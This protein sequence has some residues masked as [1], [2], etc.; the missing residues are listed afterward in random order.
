MTPLASI[1]VEVTALRS[2]KGVI[3]LCLT[4]EA[5]DFPDCRNG[6]R[7]IK[8]T[9]PAG[10]PRIRIEGI[11]PGNYAIAVIHDENGNSK[12]DTFVGIP[13]EG[14]GFSRNPG[15]GFGPPRFSR[16][17]FPVG[18]GAETQQVKLRYLL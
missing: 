4:S 13:R 6:A 11:S 3:R 5:K 7:A 18:S 17:E 16:A 10:A 2:A 8:R 14:F 1:D 12:L 15:I 9:I